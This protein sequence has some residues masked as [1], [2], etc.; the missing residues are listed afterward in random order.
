MNRRISL[1][2]ARAAALVL[3]AANG[4]LGRLVVAFAADEPRASVPGAES[5]SYVPD[6][7]PLVSQ[8][9]REVRRGN[10][11]GSL[12]AQGEKEIHDDRFSRGIA[13]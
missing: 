1:R 6:L 11:A 2:R 13:R 3:T 10:R 12:A 7:S 4:L 9:E 5:A 8:R